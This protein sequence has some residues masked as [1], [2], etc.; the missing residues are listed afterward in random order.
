M[1]C[2]LRIRTHI[3]VHVECHDAIILRERG[4]GI[5]IKVEVHVLYVADLRAVSGE[6]LHLFLAILPARKQCRVSPV[7][8]LFRVIYILVNIRSDLFNNRYGTVLYH[9]GVRYVENVDLKVQR[10]WQIHKSFVLL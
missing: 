4:G 5:L 8:V 10:L 9:L 2:L 3:H 1:A 7:G 6:M